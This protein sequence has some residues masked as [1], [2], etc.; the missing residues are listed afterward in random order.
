MRERELFLAALDIEDRAARQA[1]LKAECGGD[2]ELQARIESLLASHDRQS[3]FL[4]T[5]V[6]EQIAIG[7]DT[8]AAATM[9][10]GDGL[11][12]DEDDDNHAK[13]D[14]P[15]ATAA[16]HP[17]G[18]A[19]MTKSSDDDSNDEIPLGYL[20]P[21]S[22]PDSLGRLGH[23][24]VLE[25]VGRG[26]FG[27]VL[28]AFDEKLQ[29]VV[30]IK[31]LAP[32]MAVTSPA[33]KRFLREA[34]TSAAIRHENVVAIH[35][36]EDEPIPY[37]VMEFIPG[38]TLQQ[39]LDKSGPLSV[40]DVLKLGKQIADG[41]AAAHAQDLIHRDIKPGNILIEGGV[42]ERVKIT[43]FGLARAADDASMTQSGLIAGT[44]MYMAPEQ[45]RGDTLDQRADLFSFGSVL[46]QMLS[47]RPPFRAANTVA[48][49]KRVVDDTPRPIQEIIPEVPT[50]MCELISHLHAKNPDERIQTAKEVSDLLGRCLDDLKAGRTPKVASPSSTIASTEVRPA[51][52][53]SSR[54]SS[55]SSMKPLAR[56]A[57]VALVVLAAIGIME[58]T[59]VTKL[60]ST[61]ISRTTD[62]TAP[63]VQNLSVSQP[64]TLNAQPSG[65]HGWPADAP[66]PA[67]APFDAAQAK[68]HQEAWAKYLGV[69][70]EYTNSI[71]MKFRLIPPG[72]FLMGST[73]EEIEA[74]LQVSGGDE[75]WKDWI[76][77]EPRPHK[78]ILT[79][80]LYLGVTEVTQ[81][82]YEQLMRNNPSDFSA[83]G[84]SKHAVVEM[85]TGKHPVENVSW[86][87]AA[88]FC[89]RLS[90]KEKLKPFY[91]IVG[92]TVLPQD[93]TGYRLPTEAEWEFACR[94]GT[95][96]WYWSG[97]ANDDLR[98]VGWFG[99]NSGGRTHAVGELNPNPFG[100]FDMHG[101]VWESVQDSWDQSDSEKVNETP[102]I[103]PLRPFS[104]GSRQVFRGG[105]WGDHPTNC[106][107][108]TRLAHPA[109]FRHYG[110]G[111][112]A[113]LT[114]DAVKQRLT[115][116]P[117]TTN[118]EESSTKAG[119]TWVSLFNGQDLSGWKTLAELPGKWEVKDA[120]ITGSETTSFL[121]SERGDFENF[122][123]RVEVKSNGLGDA[124]IYFR[125]LFE[126]RH[127]SKAW[128]VQP[129]TGYELELYDQPKPRG[130]ILQIIPSQPPQVLADAI[131]ITDD[132]TGDW[133][134]V[135]LIAQGPQMTIKLN[136]REV[137]KAIDPVGRYRRGH[138][139]LALTNAKTVVQFRKI[140]LRELPPSPPPPNPEP[141]TQLFASDEWIE[142]I[143]L[144]DPKL[145]KWDMRLTGKNEWRVVNGELTAEPDEKPSNL[146][147]PID[148]DFWPSFECEL[149]CT[150]RSD[151]GAFNL[152]FPVE[153]GDTFMTFGARDNP[154]IFLTPR[155]GEGVALSKEPPLKPGERSQL[156]IEVRRVPNG[157]RITVWNGDRQLG[158]WRGD[159]TQLVG[160][161]NEGFPHNRRMSLWLFGGSNDLVFHRIRL[162][163]LDH[164]T[165][166]SIRPAADEP[167]TEAS[168]KTE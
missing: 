88:A 22:K 13:Q 116:K 104:A 18:M 162:R 45:A 55:T 119:G 27:T 133:I 40:M 82:Q 2:A 155:R 157:D 159:R 134:T 11:T 110:I 141:V 43:D 83:T 147:F 90:Q 86:N 150:L 120:A 77:S 33:R 73:P 41:L 65:W 37:L 117:N 7:S 15:N 115:A 20:Q 79:Q 74:A 114:V 98:S 51:L 23:Y 95:T 59:G 71:G 153:D 113:V 68:Q 135:E 29:R 44:P 124:G 146:I 152:N 53:S 107:S 136:G 132:D 96:T 63:V 60:A 31:V 78:V 105:N 91:S 166:H 49:L 130:S 16:Y 36:V 54:E 56:V 67:I 5:P 99:H 85:E 75:G 24:E 76:N 62:T 30:A 64:S 158:Q 21:S 50:W 151:A 38:Q 100:L 84:G 92:E 156:R 163:M 139:A 108:S 127:G 164:G 125:S 112:R 34:R 126:F 167:A 142:V 72:E 35:A 122:H 94:A 128:M 42:S 118:A 6:V 129:A 1:H 87:D 3:Q 39:R 138:F 80:P 52:S 137:N 168:K 106:R 12:H 61:V 148:A 121:F 140:E 17:S 58:V 10:V 93:G 160:I 143:P 165:A 103:N 89:S 145:D 26:A 109:T 81:S 131:R 25:V 57:A 4:N 28:R 14:A 46:Y 123:L 101:N 70:V 48:V 47:G 69:P 66:R 161:N 102:A 8:E 149:E 97:D 111:F 32:E 154:G 144:I 19:N 9:L